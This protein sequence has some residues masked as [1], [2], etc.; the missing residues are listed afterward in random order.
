MA[1]S[2]TETLD[3]LDGLRRVSLV[4][5][6]DGLFQYRIDRLVEYEDTHPYWVD[7]YPLSGLF[8]SR[9]EALAE[10][11]LMLSGADRIIS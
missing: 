3:S 2:S 7:G 6:D 4:H 10:A 5:R 8:P 9:D 1:T 11:T